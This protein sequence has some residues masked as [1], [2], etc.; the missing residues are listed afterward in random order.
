[1]RVLIVSADIGAGHDLPARLLAEAL[2]ARGAET[3]VVDA[4]GEAGGIVEAAMRTGAETVLRRLPWLFAAQYFFVATFAPTRALM[5]RLGARITRPVMLRLVEQ[6][7]P[8]VIVSTYP[9]ATEVLGRMRAAGDVDV[10]A[11]SAI[12][13]LAALRYWAHPGMDAHLIIHAESRAEV[14]QIAGSAHPI[15]HVRGMVRP[16]F[17]DPPAREDARRALGLDPQTPLVL[18]SGGG[19]G[20]GR[21]V[22]AVDAALRDPSRPN[23]ACLCGS[24]DGLRA[25]L[26]RRGDPRLHAIPF[27][28]QMVEW[29]AA[30]NVLIHST[31]GLT[32]LEAQLC[33]THAISYGWGH[34]HI[35]VNNRAYE[36]FGLAHVAATSKDLTALLPRLLSQ[37]RPR[38]E[39]PYASLAAAADVVL[40][41]SGRV[42]HSTATSPT[43][44]Q[45]P[46]PGV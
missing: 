10:P 40:E 19:W 41:A 42:P 2:E 9:G 35:R 18:V 31:A 11:V 4:I 12:T 16:A 36:R 27:T 26:T 34:G 45:T 25:R 20:V 17:E 24:N 30:A 6:H 8:D 15:V 14:A 33:G 21:L 38:H 7:R 23:V 44:I 28:D 37:E 43:A 1:M 13:D 46:P 22:A 3:V 39:P 29:M 32:M 5:Q